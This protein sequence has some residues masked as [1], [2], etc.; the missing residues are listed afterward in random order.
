MLRAE[1]ADGE[2]FAVKVNLTLSLCF[3]QFL[4]LPHCPGEPLGEKFSQG[5]ERGMSE[6]LVRC[7]PKPTAPPPCPRGTAET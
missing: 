2:R 6:G 4:D 1:L 7:N 3:D 5:S